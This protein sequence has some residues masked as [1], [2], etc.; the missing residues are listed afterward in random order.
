MSKNFDPNAFKVP[1]TVVAARRAPAVEK[2]IHNAPKV[3]SHIEKCEAAQV[4][5]NPYYQHMPKND[6][7]AA[8]IYAAK[9]GGENN[10]PAD[11]DIM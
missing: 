2:M 9:M 4:A 5:N 1:A 7:A 8:T 6:P 3:L 10:E 11:C